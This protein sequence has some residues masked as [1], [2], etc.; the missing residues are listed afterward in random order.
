MARGVNH[1]RRPLEPNQGRWINR[2]L[3]GAVNGSFLRWAKAVPVALIPSLR[4]SDSDVGTPSIDGC[5]CAAMPP[6]FIL[7]AATVGDFERSC[8]V[9]LETVFSLILD[10]KWYD[11]QCSQLGFTGTFCWPTC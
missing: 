10:S 4:C 7:F 6:L 2:S 1:C 9:L 11:Y 8:C 5:S 3:M